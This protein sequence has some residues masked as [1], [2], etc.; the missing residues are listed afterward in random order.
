MLRIKE[1]THT[2][3]KKCTRIS[4]GNLRANSACA[5]SLRHVYVT[6][7]RLKPKLHV[8]M[9][10]SPSDLE[11][12]Y[13]HGISTQGADEEV[14]ARMGY[15]QELKRDLNRLQVRGVNAFLQ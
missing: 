15:K 5:L 1:T 12:T 9:S 3:I 14:L 4:T 6:S 10:N 11:K 2:V 7:I 8:D 13:P